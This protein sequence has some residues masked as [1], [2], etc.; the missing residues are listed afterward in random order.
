MQ[1]FTD[2]L[3]DQFASWALGFIPTGGGDLGE[4]VAIAD[5]HRDADDDE[6]FD[7]WSSA[8]QRH[9]DAATSAEAAGHPAS[10]RD[11]YL[12]V[13]S[14]LT[15]ANHPLY[16]IP[17]DP[18]LRKAFDL[19][20]QAFEQAMALSE[21]P[22]EP[23]KIPFDGHDMRGYFLRAP[24]TLPGERRPLVILTNGYDATLSDMYFGTAAYTTGRG[25]HCLLF[26]GPGQGAMLVEDGVT[27]V[28]DWERV[29]APVVDYA[30]GS[31]RGRPAANRP[32]R[33]ELRRL[34]R[35]ARRER[36]ASS[37]GVCR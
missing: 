31:T 11:H 27:M 28:P 22:G 25:Y 23:I 26:D 3:L 6:F 29:V 32:A 9:Y 17:V 19:Q 21:P 5:A 33:L 8:A 35:A 15:V 1:L 14:Y 30:L 24:G 20:A 34:P 16:G 13:A 7:A 12:R 36:R 18:R 4:I 2:P 10:A 37:C